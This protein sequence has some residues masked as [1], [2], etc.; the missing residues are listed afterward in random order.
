MAAQNIFTTALIFIV[1]TLSTIVPAAIVL[2]PKVKNRSLSIRLGIYFLCG[3]TFA[4]N[5]VFLLVYLHILYTPVVWIFLVAVTVV[6]SFKTRKK[7][8]KEL[9]YII[10]DFLLKALGNDL[11]GRYAGKQLIK[12]IGNGFKA[13]GRWIK[14]Y[15]LKKPVELVA[16][17]LICIL[18]LYLY[19]A[20]IFTSYGYH[21]SDIPVHNHWIDEM[22]MHQKPFTDGLYPFAFHTVIAYLFLLFRIP[23]MYLLTFFNYAVIIYSAFFITVLAAKI[24]KGRFL[25]YLVPAIWF[26][27][28]YLN[29]NS[30][31]RY[32]AVLPQEFSTLFMVIA[33]IYALDYLQKYRNQKTY[34]RQDVISFAFALSMC[35]G[36]HL[37]PAIV[38]FLECVVIII[39]Y[40]PGILKPVCFLPLV[41]GAL[42]GVVIAGWSIG[43]GALMGIPLQGSAQWAMNV[44]NQASGSSS[45]GYVSKETDSDGTVTYQ[46]A[47]GDTYEEQPDGNVK[48]VPPKKKSLSQR[49][50][51][52]ADNVYQDM[53]GSIYYG[54]TDPVK[55]KKAAEITVA[56]YV[57]FT[58][59]SFVLAIKE[60]NYGRVLLFISI[61]GL[62]YVAL[63]CAGSLGLKVLM[64]QGRAECFFSLWLALSAVVF[65]DSVITFASDFAGRRKKL[66]LNA[67]SVAACAVFILTCFGKKMLRTPVTVTKLEANGAAVSISAIMKRQK[68]FTYTVVSA[69][70]ELRMVEAYGYHV[71]V[72]DLLKSIEKPDADT[73]FTIPT[74]KVYFFI[75]KI[76]LEFYGTVDGKRHKVSTK[77]AKKE[78]PGSEG[79]LSIY[80]GENRYVEMS[81]LYYFVNELR[82]RFP[83][84]THVYYEDGE[85][86]CVSLDQDMN[87]P[88]NLAF[89]YGYNE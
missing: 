11:G 57:F 45:V 76:P 50:K 28:R 1:Y 38:L 56:A 32:S 82:H 37:Y 87:D 53:A 64:D 23:V 72:S 39:A 16:G 22:L 73:S 3:N 27:C 89:D 78:L 59:F 15:V 8:L 36:S 65:T 71:E 88:V 70:D 7:P 24:I 58:L 86:M 6:L 62:M 34:A 12:S 51:S 41:K 31:Y 69:N 25:A 49:I 29:D 47:N 13:A 44:S 80:M 67:A 26:G 66:V 46:T 21:A 77:Y 74:E 81:R 84:Y 10:V 54:I 2:Y 42:L 85:F 83:Q 63:L 35:L 43:V 48:Q 33:L 17:L 18:L 61:S 5:V 68:P 14:K 9:P 52:K 60:R 79:G 55:G 20:G 75:E 30:V 19:K 40:L 4:A